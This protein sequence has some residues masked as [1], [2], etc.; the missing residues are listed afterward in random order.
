MISTS[1]MYTPGLVKPNIP[2]TGTK[3][4]ELNSRQNYNRL[5]RKNKALRKSLIDNNIKP[6]NQITPPSINKG[7]NQT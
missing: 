4:K 6:I 1:S 7:Q 2:Y 5:H 3:V